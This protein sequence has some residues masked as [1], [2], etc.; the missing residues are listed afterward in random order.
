MRPNLLCRELKDHGFPVWMK[1]LR[2][3][4]DYSRALGEFLAEAL[5]LAH[6]HLAQAAIQMPEAVVVRQMVQAI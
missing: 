6:H 2:L 5:A 3:E 1:L 4:M